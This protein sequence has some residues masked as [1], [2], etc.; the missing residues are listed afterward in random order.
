MNFRAKGHGQKHS[1]GEIIDKL[2]REQGPPLIHPG[3]IPSSFQGMFYCQCVRMLF[4][5]IMN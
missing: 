5:A 4:T 2:R 3:F 1:L